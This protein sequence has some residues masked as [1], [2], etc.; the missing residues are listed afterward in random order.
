MIEKS[1]REIDRF[2]S[3]SQLKVVHDVPRSIDECINH[4][5][6]HDNQVLRSEKSTKIR[7]EHH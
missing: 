7:K 6:L 1:E 2:G 3:S 5:A 4:T